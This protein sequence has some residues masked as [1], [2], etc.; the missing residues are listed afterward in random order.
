MLGYFSCVLLFATHQAPRLL[1][2]WDSPSKN[3]GVGC[4]ALFQGIFLIQES[5]PCFLFSCIGGRFFTTSATWEAQQTLVEKHKK[6]WTLGWGSNDNHI[7][8]AVV[9]RAR[10]SSLQSLREHS[11]SLAIQWNR[12]CPFTQGAW[13]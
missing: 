2:S 4:H 3:T 12:V 6:P 13:A 5:N 9:G 10:E 11:T 1:C 7:P 8:R